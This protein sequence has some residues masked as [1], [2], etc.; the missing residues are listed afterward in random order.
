MK[1]DPATR[2]RESLFDVAYCVMFVATAMVASMDIY[3]GDWVDPVF[4]IPAFV[5]WTLWRGGFRE[6]SR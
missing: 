1:T 3:V 6:P 2:T 4:Y 5:G